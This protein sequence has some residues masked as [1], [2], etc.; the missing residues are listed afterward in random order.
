MG[1]LAYPDDSPVHAM[2][3]APASG[4][5]VDIVSPSLLARSD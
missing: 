5:V 4:A 2:S 1:V 3:D